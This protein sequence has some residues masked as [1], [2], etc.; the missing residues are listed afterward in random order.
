MHGW[1]WELLIA[2]I[3]Q[4]DVWS[5]AADKDEAEREEYIKRETQSILKTWQETWDDVATIIMTIIYFALA[6]VLITEINL[7]VFRVT[8]QKHKSRK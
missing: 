6:K 2:T 5:V 4:H 3:T 7:N 8:R 1:G